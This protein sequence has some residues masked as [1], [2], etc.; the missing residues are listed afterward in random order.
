MAHTQQREFCERVKETLP[1]FFENKKV[2]DIGSLDINGSNRYLF[3]DCNYIGIDVGEGKN[4]DIV[5]LGH[6]YD[7]PDNYFD[8]IISTEVFEHDMHYPKTI[9]NV[10]RML[11]PGGLFLFTCAAPGRPEHGT[12]RSNAGDA[13]L[14]GQVSEEWADYYKNL[15]PADIKAINGFDMAFPD[16]YFEM[17]NIEPYDLYFFG[18]KGSSKY[19]PDPKDPEFPKEKFEDDIFVI[20]SWPDTESKENDLLALIKVLKTYNIPIL[21][22]G[23]YPIKPEIQKLVDYYL[24][25]KNNP[26][27]MH[28]E[29]EEYQLGS[30]RWTT[31]GDKRIDNSL[32][33]HHDYAIWETMRNAF[34]FCESLGKE[35]IHFLEYDNIPDPVQYRQAFLEKIREH[36]AVIYEYSPGSSKD[37]HF[38]AYCATYIFS[39]RTETALGVVEQIKSKEEYF[40]NRPKGWQLERI[41][42]GALQNINADIYVT[43]Y[44]AN[45]KELNTQAVWNRDGMDRG[46]AKIQVYPAVDE[47]GFLYIH[48]ISGFHE[49]PADQDYLIEVVYD[50]FHKFVTLTKGAFYLEKVGYYEKGKRLK[51]YYRGVEIYNEFL[52]ADVE[53]FRLMNCLSD[54]TSEN[55]PK[56]E[57]KMIRPTK[58]V[59]PR[60]N[61]HFVD[62]A[63]LEIL[64]PANNTY[65]IK[66]I[67]LDNDVVEYDTYITS[68]HWVKS[69]KKYVIN[70]L[71]TIEGQ[72]NDFYKEIRFEPKGNRVLINLDSK[73]LGDTIA[74]MPQVEEFRRITGAKVLCSTFKNAFLKSQYPDIK[75]IEP[76]MTVPDL[77]ALFSIGYF[78]KNNEIDLNKNPQDP[79]DVSL[80]QVA[81]DILGIPYKELRGNLPKLGKVKKKRVC[82]ANHSTCQAKYWNNPTGWQEVVD[83]LTENGYEVLNLS[84]EVDGYMGNKN[85]EGITYENDGGLQKTIKLLQESELFIGLSS[86]LS[87]LAWAAGVPTIIISGVTPTFTEP[88]EG[89]GRVI[90]E[91]VCN[92]CWASHKFDPGDWNW[93]PKRKNTKR[94]FECSKLIS[95]DSVISEIKS[96]ISIE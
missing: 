75:F 70:W 38:A 9:Q 60:I 46:G 13:P 68:N 56:K 45:D 5:S 79:R 42:L 50:D 28:E 11:K 49:D 85:P 67:D 94:M 81:S 55:K 72:G 17:K 29:F 59:N 33:F 71:I 69:D 14:L 83:F 7:G 6:E 80:M 22:T 2:L 86:G 27:L 91:K 74:W 58:T 26:L 52:G 96:M 37:T 24:F 10:I 36:D 15:T 41:F 16:G 4:V 95:A 77:Y 84:K 47:E 61:H 63:F 8:T 87:W 25:D 65:H 76:G 78:Y 57:V 89:V 39:I 44:I 31:I 35:Y 18:I 53:D 93:C 23:H 12:R 51:A 54:S 20:D 62:G 48:L 82:I 43:D 90:N 88:T 92:S 34:R 73:A 64:E 19:L 1:S 21:L 66:M 30:G 3:E 32:A 40:K